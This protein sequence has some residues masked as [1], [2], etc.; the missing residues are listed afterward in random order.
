M[1]VIVTGVLIHSA[2]VIAEAHC[3]DDD[4]ETGCGRVRKLLN[5]LH[6]LN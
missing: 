2:W 1:K 4:A 5:R 3:L 6:S